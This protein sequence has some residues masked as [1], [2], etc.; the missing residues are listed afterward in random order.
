MSSASGSETEGEEE[1]KGSLGVHKRPAAAITCGSMEGAKAIEDDP[2]AN[3]QAS[4]YACTRQN[5]YIYISI[6]THIMM[7]WKN[8]FQAKTLHSIKDGVDEEEED[9][10]VV[11]D[12]KL[13]NKLKKKPAKNLTEDEQKLLQLAADQ[14]DLEKKAA[15][16][17]KLEE[18]KAQNAKREQEQKDQ[19]Q[20][21][22][23]SVNSALQMVQKKKLEV[24]NQSMYACIRQKIKYHI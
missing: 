9:E 10:E 23:K 16:K 1:M 4:I 11:V 19:V 12:M 22:S 6:I 17:K 7:N 2:K 13:V 18:E 5:T 24:V 14:K 20:A 15:E 21:V 3:K 8:C